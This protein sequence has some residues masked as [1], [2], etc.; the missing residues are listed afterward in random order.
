MCPAHKR[1]NPKFYEYD[2]KVNEKIYILKNYEEIYQFFIRFNKSFLE[3][4]TAV[5]CFNWLDFLSKEN[6]PDKTKS[7]DR[8]DL[9]F[10][11]M[12]DIFPNPYNI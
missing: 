5:D 12:F 10:D 8:V 1:E 9:F 11:K 6:F 3:N 7:T 2:P 4:K